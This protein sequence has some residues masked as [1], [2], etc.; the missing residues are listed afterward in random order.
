[1][2]EV[3]MDEEQIPELRVDVHKCIYTYMCACVHVSI[4]ALCCGILPVTS[5]PHPL[6]PAVQSSSHRP[7]AVR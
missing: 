5:T 4:L 6:P 1:M 7:I 3:I 2:M